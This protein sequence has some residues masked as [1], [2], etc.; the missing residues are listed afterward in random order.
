[1]YGFRWGFKIILYTKHAHWYKFSQEYSL[2]RLGLREFKKIISSQVFHGINYAYTLIKTPLVFRMRQLL[3]TNRTVCLKNHPDLIFSV[4]N[5][6]KMSF[7]NLYLGVNTIAFLFNQFFFFSG[8][9]WKYQHIYR[10]KS[11]ATNVTRKLNT[12]LP[13]CSSMCLQI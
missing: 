10:I 2:W 8:R 12:G 13:A 6:I 4:K 1:M 9:H 5:L 11:K 7:N 3:C